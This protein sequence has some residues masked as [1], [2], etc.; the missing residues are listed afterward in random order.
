MRLVLDAPHGAVLAEWPRIAIEHRGSVMFGGSLRIEIGH[1]VRF[2]PGV[3]IEVQPGVDSRLELADHVQVQAGAHLKLKGG[4]IRVGPGTLLRNMSVLKSGGSLDVGAACVISYGT[5]VHCAE[6]VTIED[7]VGL[8]DRTTVVDSSHDVDGSDVPW[9]EQ[10]DPGA[11]IVIGRNTMTFANAVILKGAT[12][13][14]NS[15]VGAAA[16]VEDGEYPPGAVLAGA[17]AEVIRV[18]SPP[19]GRERTGV[20]AVTDGT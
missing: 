2:G 6:S 10:P 15:V 9:V 18:L 11:P 20:E 19:V 5:V 12:L 8:G 14:P 13:G 1:G 16:V 3:T 7:R 17:P 4:S